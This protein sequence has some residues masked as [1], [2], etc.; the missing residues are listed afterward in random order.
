M[1]LLPPKESPGKGVVSLLATGLSG[2]VTVRFMIKRGF[3]IRLCSS[4]TDSEYG[5]LGPLEFIGAEFADDTGSF[6]VGKRHGCEQGK[7]GASVGGLPVFDSLFLDL[8]YE[9]HQAAGAFR[10]SV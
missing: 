6:F 5:H 10:H 3:S 8:Q 7:D 9:A 2:P 4:I 1:E